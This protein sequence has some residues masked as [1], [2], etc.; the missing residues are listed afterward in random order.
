M[1]SSC[2]LFDEEQGK[3]SGSQMNHLLGESGM[4]EKEC[5]SQF[6]ACLLHF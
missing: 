2:D 6:P 3:T 1:G 4:G 5:K